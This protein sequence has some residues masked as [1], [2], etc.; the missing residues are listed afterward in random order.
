MTN[1]IVFICHFQFV[2]KS[3]DEKPVFFNVPEN[4]VINTDPGLPTAVVSWQQPSAT[5]N[6]G[7]SVTITSNFNSSDTFP[8]GITN[9]TYTATDTSGNEESAMFSITIIGEIN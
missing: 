8:I 9:V 2:S 4:L 5:D 7:G 1:T 6:S 3:D